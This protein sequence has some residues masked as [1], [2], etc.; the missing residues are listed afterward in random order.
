VL[1]YGLEIP[2]GGVC[3]DPRVLAEL[4][5]IAE[6]AGFDGI[7][8]EDYITYW[9]EPDCPTADPWIALAAMAIATE[10]IRLGTTVTAPARRR[11]WKLA[12]ETVTL[13][14]LSGGRIT[15]A[16]GLGDATEPGFAKVSEEADPSI[17]AQRLDESLEILRGLWSGR[18]FSYSG[19]HYRI[20]DVLF[21]PRPLQQPTIPLWVGGGWPRKAVLSRALRYD[22]IC[23]YKF[24]P[25]NPYRDADDRIMPKDVMRI[26]A[27]AVEQRGEAADGF[28]IVLL[29]QGR[30]A[31]DPAAERDR[32][33]ELAEAGM[34]WAMEWVPAGTEKQ[35]KAAVA[36]GP[37]RIAP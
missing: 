27:A 3:A 10:R 37:L 4:A 15:L 22:G 1:H 29:N 12:R 2:N 14:H 5:V 18:R 25:A 11:P 17:R 26:R 7:F 24:D 35:M 9:S 20:D 34:T 13:D 32:I 16:A 36:Q 30:R 28:D 31:G 19:R 33:A 21:A 23:P 8:C 6:E